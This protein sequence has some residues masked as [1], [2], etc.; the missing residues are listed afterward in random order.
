M[1]WSFI[2]WFISLY[3]KSLLNLFLMT[4]AIN[5]IFIKKTIF[6]FFFSFLQS[7]GFKECSYTEMWALLCQQMV[8]PD[9]DDCNEGKV[10]ISSIINLCIATPEI[11]ATENNLLVKGE[12]KTTAHISQVMARCVLSSLWEPCNLCSSLEGISQRSK[13]NNNY[14]LPINSYFCLLACFDTCPWWC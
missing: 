2:F 8:P 9:L 10:L 3:I 13:T 1:H 5:K 12:V 4:L 6:K 11:L 7:S 14:I